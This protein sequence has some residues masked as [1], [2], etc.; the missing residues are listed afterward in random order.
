MRARLRGLWARLLACCFQSRCVGCRTW[1]PSPVCAPCAATL[2]RF[3]EDACPR[4]RGSLTPCPLCLSPPPL[5]QVYAV[6]PYEGLIRRAIHGVK[7]DGRPELARWL[8]ARMAETLTSLDPDW[9][10]VPVPLSRERLRQR[11][12]NQAEWL[13]LGIPGHRKAPDWLI[14]TRHTP[15]QVGHGSKQRWVGLREAFQAARAVDGQRILLVDDVLTS[16]ATLTWA[17]HA[18]RE[19]GARE[20]RA[21]VAAR[22][23]LMQKVPPSGR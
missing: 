1:G 16:G 5:D 14:R 13:A 8:G 17:A 19:A 23:Q 20:V 22:A 18:L 12:Y 10:L 11:G 3:P 2:P 4:C 6:A 21:V 9:V 15:S 7:F